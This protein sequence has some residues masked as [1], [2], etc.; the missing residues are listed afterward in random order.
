LCHVLA[1]LKEKFLTELSTATDSSL[2]ISKAQ[3]NFFM[4]E[5][6]RIFF[7]WLKS[8][9]ST[10]TNFGYY[11]QTSSGHLFSENP[12]IVECHC[13]AFQNN[14]SDGSENSNGN[15]KKYFYLDESHFNENYFV[16][17]LT[18]FL[19][20]SCESM[21]KAR[22]IDCFDAKMNAIEICSDLV[23]LVSRVSVFISD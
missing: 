15:F 4:N 23:N 6:R 2:S 9:V 21:Q 10:S 13:G 3:M 5:V 8:L 19:S 16:Y 1:K 18:L 11:I 14:V 17:D 7:A 12:K 20:D 22:L